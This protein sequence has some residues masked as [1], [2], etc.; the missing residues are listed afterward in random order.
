MTRTVFLCR[1]PPY[2]THPVSTG[3]RDTFRVSVRL[4]TV[5]TLPSTEGEGEER[6]TEER[7]ER[8][9]LVEETGLGFRTPEGRGTESRETS[10]GGE[11]VGVVDSFLRN[12]CRREKGGLRELG[13]GRNLARED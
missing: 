13:V 6:G 2:S 7:K 5:V 10:T 3:G 11:P 9:E 1:S 12:G 4:R 8:E